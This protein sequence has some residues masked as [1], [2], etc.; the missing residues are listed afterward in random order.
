VTLDLWTSVDDYL[1]ASLLKPDEALDAAVEATRA[2]GLPEIQVSAPQGQLLHLLAKSIGARSIL[3]IGTLGGYSAIWL[4]RA[5]PPGGR[6]LT[7]ELDPHHADVARSNLAHAGL[8]DRVEVRTGRAAES[9]AELHE[10]GAGPFDFFFIDADKPSNPDY[11]GWA[12]DH[13]RP[14]SLIVVD[15]VV[16]DGGVADA[17]SSDP[18]AL[19]SRQVVELAGA[20]PRVGA[21]AIQTVGTKGYDGFLLARVLP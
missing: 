8:A 16:R 14:G 15:N 5:L 10:A 1:T 3:E 2:G 18:S 17:A 9:L 4:G 19:G 11:Y 12:V 20:D 13:A 21:T 6:M 7:L